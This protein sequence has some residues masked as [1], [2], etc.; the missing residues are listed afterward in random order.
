MSRPAARFRRRHLCGI[1]GLLASALYALVPS[2]GQAADETSIATFPVSFAVT[3]ND[4]DPVREDEWLD[5]QLAFAEKLFGPH[6]VHFKRTSRRLVGSLYTELETRADRDAL[7]AL[8]RKDVINVFVVSSL[9]DVDEK[10]RFRSG[11]HWRPSQEPTSRY[12]ILSATAPPSVLAHELGHYFGN[13]HSPTPDNIMSYTRK[14]GTLF[15]D[16]AQVT[17]IR[18]TARRCLQERELLPVPASSA[19]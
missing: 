19:R 11:V 9:R 6:G 5:E 12:V 1:A 14:G 4:G 7:F 2:L 16:A 3:Q 13:P 8:A 10:D 17:K 15:L 18:A